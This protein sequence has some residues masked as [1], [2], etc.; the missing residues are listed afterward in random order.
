MR[1]SLITN[2]LFKYSND[3]E[4]MFFGKRPTQFARSPAN[5]GHKVIVAHGYCS[6]GTPF[7]AEDFPGAMIFL[8]KKANRDHDTFALML[9]E[10]GKDTASFSVI[11]HSQGGPAAL[12]LLTFYW[13]KQDTS[14][15]PAGK[16]LIQTVG[17]PWHGSG[18]AGSM[19]SIGSFFGVGCGKNYDLS[20]EGSEQWLATI[21]AKTRALVYY[22]TTQFGKGGSCSF[23]ANWVLESPNDGT[24]EIQYATL[25]SG[26][27]AS[28]TIGQCHVTEMNFPPQ[29]HDHAR[30]AE[31]FAFAQM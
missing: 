22:H 2:P 6:E 18:L 15:L 19:A 9:G 8:D 24:T 30:N 27:F 17:S 14:A 1:L 28:N 4:S 7:S 16:R 20:H 3:D 26:N 31:M 10:F 29:C 21:P 11:G 23:G 13:S 12:H 5:S 25:E